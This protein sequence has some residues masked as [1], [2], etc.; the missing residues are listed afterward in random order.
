VQTRETQLADGTRR[1]HAFHAR[2]APHSLGAAAT[3][4]PTSAATTTP[5]PFNFHGRTRAPAA[6]SLEKQHGSAAQHAPL[7]SIQGSL[8]NFSR[9]LR[10]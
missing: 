1:E 10:V 6:A 9:S 8:D 5:R 4:A 3:R 2:P 7:L